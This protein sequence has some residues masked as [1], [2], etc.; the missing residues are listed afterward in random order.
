MRYRKYAWLAITV[1]IA[2]ELV[3]SIPADVWAGD[4]ENE[5]FVITVR[6]DGGLHVQLKGGSAVIFRPDFII[7]YNEKDPKLAFRPGDFGKVSYNVATWYTGQEGDKTNLKKVDTTKV[8]GDGF[9]PSV[10]QGDS[11]GRT[12]NYLHAAPIARISAKRP[13]IKD[14]VV[15][16]EFPAHPSF[17]L[18]AQVELPQGDAFPVLTVRFRPSTSG[19]YSIGYAGAPENEPAAVDDVWQPLLWQGKR[20][21]KQSFLTMAYRCPIPTALT[22]HNGYTVGVVADPN[23]LPFEPLPTSANSRFGVLVRNENGKA[24]PMLF[25]PVLGGEGSLMQGEKTFT[26]SAHFGSL[27]RQYHGGI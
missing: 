14:N 22:T 4:L 19:Y 1:M 3:L 23:L 11:Q 24:Q 25:S 13:N 27:P 2:C 5:R 8:A 16:C 21:P 6:E 9:D 12:S 20:F 26:F 17:H 7:L 18:S 15:R 10:L